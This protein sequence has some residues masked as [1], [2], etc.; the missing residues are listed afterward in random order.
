M[1]TEIIKI[2]S[3]KIEKNKI[4]S[5]AKII[6]SGGLVAFPTETVYGLGADAFNSD[7]VMNIFKAKN[8]PADNPLIV[9]VSG[10][11]MLE[12]VVKEISP[13]ARKLIKKYWPGPLTLVLE[14]SDEV[15]DSV[16]CGLKTV[17]VRMP[18]NK[19]ALELIKKSGVP[20]AA[21]SANLSSS[22]SSTSAEHVLHDLDGRIDLILDGGFCDIGLES[23]VLDIS[24]K[25]PRLLR[26]GKVS[27][28][29]LE[30]L[31]GKL[32]SNFSSEKPASPGMKYKHY[33]PKTPVFLVDRSQIKNQLEDL[34]REG[35]RVALL[36]SKNE[37]FESEFIFHFNEDHT[38][39]AKEMFKLLRDLDKKIFDCILIEEIEEKGLGHAI[40]NR[41]RK[42][43]S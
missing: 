41:L 14:K 35:K 33:S 32:D 16:S 26:P 11:Q 39:L 42:A 28:E 23:T 18:S 37:N 30:N 10:V 34:H 3:E 5:A 9:H 17:A 25:I 21:P 8:R 31:L 15:P 1:M 27:L 29:E 13:L 40:M 22:P 20:I 12:E 2:N 4:A 38:L 19:I 36:V 7:A 24:G 43:A 6:N